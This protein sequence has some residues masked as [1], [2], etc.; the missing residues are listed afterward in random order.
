MSGFAHSPV[1]D[2]RL[3]AQGGRVTTDPVD[4]TCPVCRFNY[5]RWALV[6][7]LT[8]NLEI[9]EEVQAAY[10]SELLSAARVLYNEADYDG[11]I[12]AATTARARSPRCCSSSTTPSTAR[13]WS[14]R[15][16]RPSAGNAPKATATSG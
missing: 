14:R 5:A 10:T 15:T 16:S 13:S 3:R 2:C 9:S 12:A 1:G 4:V 11:A 8:R 7:N 6:G